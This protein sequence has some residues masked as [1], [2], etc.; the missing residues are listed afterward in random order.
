MEFNVERL[1]K[2]VKERPAIWDTTHNKWYTKNSKLKAWKEIVEI[3]DRE[4]NDANIPTS[5]LGPLIQKRWKN[6][7]DAH[8]KQMKKIQ[9][10]PDSGLGKNYRLM[11]RLS[12]LNRVITTGG[13]NLNMT[14]DTEADIWEDTE[15][16]EEQEH[17]PT[18][19]R[20]RARVKMYESDDNDVI[21]GP[22]EVDLDKLVDTEETLD[23]MHT[24]D[25]LETTMDN[26]VES[27]PN[28]K[29]TI[30]CESEK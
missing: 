3:I 19:T 9:E 4:D 24:T 23:I 28:K 13:R 22:E 10:N 17:L 25:P 1:I 7:R 15:E 14:T 20:S 26:S 8:V 21:V 30:Q 5:K 6:L 16:N 2:V 11:D 12:F 27:P 18:F 29:R